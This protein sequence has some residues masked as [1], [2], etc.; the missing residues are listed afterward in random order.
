M[1]TTK[2]KTKVHKCSVC[3]YKSL[4][5]TQVQNHL[6]RCKDAKVVTEDTIVSHYDEHDTEKLSSM[7]YQCS[8]CSYTSS[9]P[10]CL[11]RHLTKCEGD[12]LSSKR[13]LSFSHVPKEVTRFV[14]NGSTVNI[15]QGEKSIAIGHDVNVF[16]FYFAPGTPDETIA[17][18]AALIKALTP[19]SDASKLLT[20]SDVSD[21]PAAIYK[22]IRET[23]P[24]LDNKL[25]NKNDVVS[26]KDGTR[27]PRVKHSKYE[28]SRLMKTLYDS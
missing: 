15:T 7:L 11:Q 27:V 3:D 4:I 26:K 13:I 21:F 12:M 18:V 22:I 24:R 1:Q 8:K 2:F 14:G 16:N 25:I 9:Q 23:D 20:N 5:K 17:A 28:L 6:K 19:N 10:V